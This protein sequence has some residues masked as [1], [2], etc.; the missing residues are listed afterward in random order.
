MEQ[1]LSSASS[2]NDIGVALTEVAAC[3]R[4]E[5]A[6]AATLLLGSASELLS[7]LRGDGEPEPA[8][9]RVI[10][11]IGEAACHL[12]SVRELMSEAD[13]RI[14]SYL[15]AIGYSAEGQDVGRAGPDLGA[16]GGQKSAAKAES[17]GHKAELIDVLDESGNPTG[18]KVDKSDVHR[19]GLWHRDVHVWVT[20]GRHILEQQR[21][22]DKS[23][24]PGQWDISVGGHVMAGETFAEAA[25]RET[26]EEI[27]IEA[28]EAQLFYAG[29]FVLE[30]PMQS[31]S[32]IHRIFGENYVLVVPDLKA[33]SLR[34]QAEEVQGA[35]LYSIDQLEADLADPERAKLHAEQPVDL[36]KLGIAAMRSAVKRRNSQ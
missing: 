8:L 25:L 24:M 27:G 15:N 35:R 11:C 33:D 28:D 2:I 22:W 7:S 13:G 6:E 12:N 20:D 10:A 29:R 23:I 1:E 34:L 18:Q 16:C 21:N 5:N 36:W 26:R 14:T 19:D 9:A 31:G 30:L 3:L 4:S 17:T 32:W